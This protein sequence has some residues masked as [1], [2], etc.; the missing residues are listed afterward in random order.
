MQI[1]VIVMR[2]VDGGNLAPPRAIYS[3]R[4]PDFGTLPADGNLR[5]QKKPGFSD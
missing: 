4:A 5:A 2:T 1:V 3:M